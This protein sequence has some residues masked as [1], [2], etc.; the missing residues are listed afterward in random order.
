[1]PQIRNY[2]TSPKDKG[3]CKKVGSYNPVTYALTQ[4]FKEE[5][6]IVTTSEENAR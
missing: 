2:M 5:F 1:M 4:E 3:I 6:G